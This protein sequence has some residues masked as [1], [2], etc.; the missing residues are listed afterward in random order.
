MQKNT[1]RTVRTRPL[2]PVTELA[3]IRG[4][5]AGCVAQWAAA[6]AVAGGVGTSP[7]YDDDDLLPPSP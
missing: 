3:D 1:K 5:L 7:S 6:G 2:R 4:G